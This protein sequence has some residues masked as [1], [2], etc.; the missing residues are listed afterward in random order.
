MAGDNASDGWKGSSSCLVDTAAADLTASA[1]WV[2]VLASCSIPLASLLS[3]IRPP[4]S[5]ERR[6]LSISFVMISLS[7]GGTPRTSCIV[8][9]V[10]LRAACTAGVTFAGVIRRNIPRA[11]CAS[12]RRVCAAVVERLVATLRCHGVLSSACP[13]R[14]SVVLVAP[15]AARAGPGPSAPM[16]AAL[17]ETLWETGSRNRCGARVPAPA[18]VW[19]RKKFASWLPLKRRRADGVRPPTFRSENRVGA[20]DRAP[21]SEGSAVRSRRKRC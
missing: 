2:T 13:V 20:V 4:P 19:W 10:R 17:R 8:A 14:R 9:A 18:L 1:F 5:L 6:W 16:P 7:R 15:F 12:G 11:A 3:G 21:L